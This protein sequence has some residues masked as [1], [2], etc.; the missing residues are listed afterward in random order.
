MPN[1]THLRT[2]HREWG[3]GSSPAH[4]ADPLG[5]LMG[6]T[7]SS[8][9]T[10]PNNTAS[11]WSHKA[12]RIWP[13]LEKLCIWLN[14]PVSVRRQGSNQL[15]GPS[16]KPWDK[17]NVRYD[18]RAKPL[19]ANVNS[20]SRDPI[21]LRTG[22]RIYACF[23]KD[24][25]RIAFQTSNEVQDPNL[26]RQKKKRQNMGISMSADLPEKVIRAKTGYFPGSEDALW[27]YPNKYFLAWIF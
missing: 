5:N 19:E 2:G 12:G 27:R 3:K 4:K 15:S 10:T 17:N 13:Q 18:F 1:I 11:F 9:Q 26:P 25:P 22:K 8:K 16:I 23:W 14:Y 7:R 6:I 24:Q 21:S 20:A